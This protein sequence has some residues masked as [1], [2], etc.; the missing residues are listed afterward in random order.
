MGAFNPQESPRMQPATSIL[1][2]L[3]AS[4]LLLALSACGSLGHST[5]EAPEK[6]TRGQ[7]NVG[8]SLLYQEADGIPKLNWLIRFKDKSDDMSQVTQDLVTY[9]QQLAD[10]LQKLSKQFPAVRVDVR[11]MPEIIADTR[12]GI[13]TDM[14]KDIA[15]VIGKS[16]TEFEREAL[17]TFH[18]S[19]N[20]QRHLVREMLERETVPALKDFLE[21]TRYQLDS[22]YEK[23]GALLS[24][25]YF[26]H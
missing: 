14:A 5:K 20:E 11:T 23:V 12:K 7:L 13:G 1:T 16:G 15:P 24:R 17:L 8:Y 4:A 10:T 19:L 2:R 26:A 25:R 6:N 22:R 18:D 9:Y 21:T 3:L